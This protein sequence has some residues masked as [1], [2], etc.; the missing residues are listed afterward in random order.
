MPFESTVAAF[1]A[2]LCD[3]AA[4]PPAATRGR[5][6]APDARRFA[7]YRNN[8]AVGLIGALEARY[9][10]SRRMAG[11]TLF[12]DIA[13]AFASARKP[14]SP[15]MI[16]Y[17]GEFPEFI[18]TYIAGADA[19]TGQEEIALNVTRRLPWRVSSPLVGEDQG[20]G[21]PSYETKGQRRFR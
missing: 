21:R 2:A 5:C 10:V 12:R 7:V 13:R 4:P 15:V 1:A 18:A 20:G 8:V 19:G 16:A 11:D 6:G 9:P 17:G 14:R 3:P